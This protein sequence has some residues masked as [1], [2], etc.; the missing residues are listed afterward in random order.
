MTLEE[1]RAAARLW[2]DTYREDIAD[3]KF[4]NEARQR[5]RS[6]SYAQ[7]NLET[8]NRSKSTTRAPG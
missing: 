3:R 8:N 4:I 1:K 2:L 6:K 5:A 7:W